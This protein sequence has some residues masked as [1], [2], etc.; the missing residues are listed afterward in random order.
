[1]ARVPISAASL[2]LLEAHGLPETLLREVEGDLRKVEADEPSKGGRVADGGQPS[3]LRRR[4]SVPPT[5]KATANSDGG[6]QEQSA[7]PLH[8]HAGGMDDSA[9]IEG[10]GPRALFG[11]VRQRTPWL[12]L[13]LVGLMLTAVVMHRFEKLLE[14]E[15]ELAYFVPLLIGQAGNSGGQA[16]STVIRA[17]GQKD[18]VPRS[19]L[20]TVSLEATAGLVQGTILACATG[21]FLYFAMGISYNVCLA[22]G[23]SIPALSTLANTLGSMLPFVVNYLGFDPA[24]IVGPLMTTS[25]D[26]LGLSIYLAIGS[27]FLPLKL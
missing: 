4:T 26:T 11:I 7:A 12:M 22:V 3:T 6:A 8:G 15:L 24:V 23:T 2:L 25:C 20:A 14:R 17:L 5:S 16:V 19:A 10:S 21:P 9:A 13:F 27:L 1:M 18:K